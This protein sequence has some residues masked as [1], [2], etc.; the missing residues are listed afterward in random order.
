M[1]FRGFFKYDPKISLRLGNCRFTDK[2]KS[3][4]KAC[5]NSREIYYTIPSKLQSPNNF[6]HHSSPPEIHI[7]QDIIQKGKR[8]WSQESGTP[9]PRISYRNCH[10]AHPDVVNSARTPSQKA[11]QKQCQ[12]SSQRNPK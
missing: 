10:P 6:P 7:Q 12:R 2:L 3:L 11:F 5:I 8:S 9:Y 1:G 4:L